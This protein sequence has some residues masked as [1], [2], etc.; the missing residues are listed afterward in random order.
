MSPLVEKKVQQNYV[1]HREKET[2]KV[3]ERVFKGGITKGEK[4]IYA[5][6]LIAVVWVTYAIVSNYATMYS[7]NHEMQQVES[8]LNNQENVNS[9][10]TLQVK[11]LS[12]PER[13]LDIAQNELGMKLND[14][15]V[16]VIH[17]N[18]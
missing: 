17:S 6:A 3:R 9:G 16:K 10:L 4:V 15:S 11:E 5:M 13:I 1:P 14:E 18:E 2:K 12:D 7:L 8:Q